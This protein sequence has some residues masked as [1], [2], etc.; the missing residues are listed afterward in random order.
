MVLQGLFSIPVWDDERKPAV[1]E[2]ARGEMD[3]GEAC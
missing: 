2:L 1:E 3:V